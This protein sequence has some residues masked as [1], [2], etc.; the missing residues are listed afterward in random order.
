MHLPA[1]SVT[2]QSIFQHQSLTF[3]AKPLI[4]NGLNKTELNGTTFAL[5]S[6]KAS[7]VKAMGR[8]RF[9]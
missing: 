8:S 2:I 5:I 7:R 3:K 6:L 9:R 4:T 1:E